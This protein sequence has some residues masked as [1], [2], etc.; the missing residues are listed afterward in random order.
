MVKKQ[1]TDSMHNLS[2]TSK[3]MVSADGTKCISFIERN[4][5]LGLAGEAE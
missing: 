5:L 4:K 3:L 1:I 2:F